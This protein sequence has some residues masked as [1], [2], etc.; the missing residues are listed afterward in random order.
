L[1]LSGF[2][3]ITALGYLRLPR[4]VLDRGGLSSTSKL[5]YAELLPWANAHGMAC[6][7]REELCRNLQCCQRQ[8]RSYLAELVRAGL[9]RIEHRGGGP[10]RYTFVYPPPHDRPTD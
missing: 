1:D 2:E 7:P 9:L 3:A 10:D 4:F 5:L 8:L 6:P